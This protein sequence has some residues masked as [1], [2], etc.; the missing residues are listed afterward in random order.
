MKPHFNSYVDSLYMPSKSRKTISPR[1]KPFRDVKKVKHPL[2][3]KWLMNQKSQN[4]DLIAK[5]SKEYSLSILDHET[6]NYL[7]RYDPIIQIGAN[8]GYL[9]YLLEQM[10]IEVMAFDKNPPEKQW[11]VVKVG[12]DRHVKY[13]P[14]HN[15]LLSWPS[16][17]HEMAFHAIKNFKE[18]AKARYFIYLG[19]YRNIDGSLPKRKYTTATEKFFNYLEK[20][21]H[22]VAEKSLPNWKITKTKLYVYKK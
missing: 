6:I 21:F 12:T 4:L 3:K 7:K 10:G 22:K 8:N 20:H 14:H 2:L 15:L 19:E 9:A 16:P 11:S 18:S 13:Y 1:R 5:W 17:H